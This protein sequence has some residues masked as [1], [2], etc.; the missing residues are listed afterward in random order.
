[1]APGTPVG[2]GEILRNRIEAFATPGLAAQDA[3]EAEPETG[4][5]AMQ[6]DRFG[7][8]VR[9]GRQIA[10]A[11][12]EHRRYRQL[13]EPDQ[14]QEGPRHRPPRLSLFPLMMTFAHLD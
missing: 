11:P 7:G 5:G 13:I 9:A 12:A 3:R 6:P 8:I 2:F 4:P 1:M 10:A 14:P